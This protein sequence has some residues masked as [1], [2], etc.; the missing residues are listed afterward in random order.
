MVRSMSDF[1]YYVLNVERTALGCLMNAALLDPEF[2]NL[3]IIRQQ[4]RGLLRD[5]FTQFDTAKNRLSVFGTID[6]LQIVH[7]INKD[8]NV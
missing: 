1:M 7:E 4:K 5:V 6:A 3:E 2:R 8:C